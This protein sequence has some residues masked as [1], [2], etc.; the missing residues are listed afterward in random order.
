MLS[1]FNPFSSEFCS[2][3]IHMFCSDAATFALVVTLE[4][5]LLILLDYHVLLKYLLKK[6][7]EFLRAFSASPSCDRMNYH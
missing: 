7:E 1:Y 5:S 4:T 6:S 3:L 2:V